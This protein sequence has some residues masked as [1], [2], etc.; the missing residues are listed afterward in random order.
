MK[1]DAPPES[2]II[3]SNVLCEPMRRSVDVTSLNDSS[4]SR[5]APARLRLAS[6]APSTTR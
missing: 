6:T 1:N 3:D 2:R 4:A 5:R